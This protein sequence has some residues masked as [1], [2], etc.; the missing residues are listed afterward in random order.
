MSLTIESDEID[1]LAERLA[2]LSR[3]DKAEAVRSAL[4]NELE[5]REGRPSLG[6][7]LRPLLDRIDAVPNSGLPA[8]KAFYDDLSGEP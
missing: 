3:V 6:D 5:R 7:R 8:D 2:S 1:R 4:V